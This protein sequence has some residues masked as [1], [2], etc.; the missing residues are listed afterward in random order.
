[1]GGCFSAVEAA[2]GLFIRA[3]LAGRTLEESTRPAHP[4][5]LNSDP[6]TLPCEAAPTDAVELSLSLSFS[7][8][9]H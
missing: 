9:P 7:F 8:Y 4:L 6:F 3:F 2:V 5:I 1:M